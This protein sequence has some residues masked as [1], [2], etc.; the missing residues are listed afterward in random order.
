MS[1]ANKKTFRDKEKSIK[2]F[3]KNKKELLPTNVFIANTLVLRGKATWIIEN[4]SLTLLFN[5]SDYRKLRKYVIDKDKR[6]CY[7]CK[8]EILENDV[9]TVDHIYPKSKFGK[10]DENNL[11]C[12]CKRCN[13]DKRDMDITQYYNHIVENKSK[14]K[15]LDLEYLRE[16]TLK[17][18]R[19]KG[20]YS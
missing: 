5:K 17:Y 15:Y 12:C 2:V 14:Y 20:E 1:K 4:E 9:I 8:K 11:R 3:D 13:D 16:V 6:I 7:I 10:D 19:D 18:H